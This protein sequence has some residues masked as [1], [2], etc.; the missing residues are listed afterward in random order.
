[1]TLSSPSSAFGT[2]RVNVSLCGS[3]PRR[4]LESLSLTSGRSSN[5]LS[6]RTLNTNSYLLEKNRDAPTSTQPKKSCIASEL[7]S[8]LS[9]MREDH[10]H[11]TGPQRPSSLEFE[12]PSW[13]V[14]A[15]GDSR[16]EVRRSM[17]SLRV[18]SRI[19]C[20]RFLTSLLSTASFR[21]I[22][23]TSLREPEG[24]CRLSSGPFAPL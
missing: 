17:P 10:V 11:R 12:A 16:L 24:A 8:Y 3:V 21:Y 5:V 23:K 14:P 19:L 2:V 6:S 15:R 18:S 9:N 1:M 7:C 4:E 20:F 22:I 13:A